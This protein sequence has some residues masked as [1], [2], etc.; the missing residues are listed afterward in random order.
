[1]ARQ[2]AI[3]VLGNG[4]TRAYLHEDAMS[5]QEAEL[6]M[7]QRLG[8]SEEGIFAVQS[9]L[10]NTY[11]ELGRS[12]EANRMLRDVYSGRL[13]LNGE[14]HKNTLLAAG[15]YAMALIRLQRFE[16]A[17][18]LQRKMI[19]VARRVF[20]P[21]HDYTLRMRLGYATALC[22]DDAATLDD[23]HEAVMTLEDSERIARRVLGGAYPLTT[24]IEAALQ[25]AREA[26]SAR[27]TPSPP[28]AR[29]V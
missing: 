26:L 16:E 18:A 8:A 7:K 24:A 3:N 25:N 13:R 6:S 4:L 2:I 14:E 1:M 17:K 10:A 23:L 22:R 9:N 19:P 21:S 20:G 5:V 12:E 27:E 15:N 29:S 11:T 28:P